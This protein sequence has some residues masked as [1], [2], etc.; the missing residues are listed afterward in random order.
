MGAQREILN[1]DIEDFNQRRRTPNLP[2]GRRLQS[3]G[4]FLG[5]KGI[6]IVATAKRRRM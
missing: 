3:T 4:F 5:R 1:D 2:N 6:N